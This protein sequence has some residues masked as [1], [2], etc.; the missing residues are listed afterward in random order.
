MAHYTG[1]WEEVIRN[2]ERA[3]EL[4]PLVGIKNRFAM[5]YYAT[6]RKEEALQ[7]MEERAPRQPFGARSFSNWARVLLLEG[8]FDGALALLE[9][10]NV[11]GHQIAV[12]AL[13]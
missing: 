3:H 13:A 4:D 11:D 1:D 10:E 12:R 6:G 7:L 9:K 8:D 5:V 2:A